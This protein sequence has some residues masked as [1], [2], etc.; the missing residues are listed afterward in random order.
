MGRR[1]KNT[2]FW[3]SRRSHLPVIVVGAIVVAVLFFDDETS[4]QLNV[5]YQQQINRLNKEIRLNRDSAAYYRAKREAVLHG[6]GQLEQI[7]RE[8]YHMQRPTED[9]YIIDP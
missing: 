8:Q 5:Q 4:M 9:V 3:L 2:M 7:A 1:I 6:S